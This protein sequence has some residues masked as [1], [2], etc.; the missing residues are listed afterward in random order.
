MP[1]MRSEKMVA[2]EMEK[3]VAMEIKGEVMLFFSL[4]PFTIN[5]KKLNRIREKRSRNKSQDIL[6]VPS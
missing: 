2:M 4:M 1:I 5:K 3:M 6:K